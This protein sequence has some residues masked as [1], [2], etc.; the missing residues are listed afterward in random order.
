MTTSI[1]QISFI[2]IVAGILA[3]CNKTPS[4]GGKPGFAMPPPEV[5]VITATPGNAMLTQ[6]LPGRLQ[7]Y[8]TA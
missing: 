1:K 5:E 4:A 7:A 2:V 3:G 6:D 8:R